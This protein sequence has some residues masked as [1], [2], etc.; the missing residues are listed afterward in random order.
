M[1]V[2][3]EGNQ[4]KKIMQNRL[5]LYQITALNMRKVILGPGKLPPCQLGKRA[6]WIST[7]ALRVGFSAKN[8]F[9]QWEW[10]KLV[11]NVQ[12]IAKPVRQAM[13]L[14]W[15][16]MTKKNIRWNEHV[17][18]T[19]CHQFVFYKILILQILKV[20][21]SSSTQRCH[22]VF[23]CRTCNFSRPAKYHRQEKSPALRDGSSKWPGA[24][25][26]HTWVMKCRAWVVDMEP[27]RSLH[28]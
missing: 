22:I 17:C 25:K 26:P 2:G 1:N 15:A 10:L 16:M 18:S 3:I 28:T 23:C 4:Q 19:I 11:K 27:V 12:A 13:V 5:F 24:K 6:R 14:D 20:L 9:H 7:V 8:S 21:R